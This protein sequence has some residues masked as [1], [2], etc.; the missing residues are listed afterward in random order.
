MRLSLTEMLV[1]GWAIL[2]LLMWA[3]YNNQKKR[4]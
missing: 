1:I 4:K 2:A 3:R